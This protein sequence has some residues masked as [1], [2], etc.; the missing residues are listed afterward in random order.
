[1]SRLIGQPVAVQ[2]R[3]DGSP[4]AFNWHGVLYRVRVLSRWKLATRW[5]SQRMRW[6]ATTS[7][8]SPL[9]SKYVSC[10]LRLRL[11]RR[12]RTTNGGC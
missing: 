11:R 7:L 9:T 2:A 10:T 1:M 8:S 4:L 5:R 6:T 12:S 3:A